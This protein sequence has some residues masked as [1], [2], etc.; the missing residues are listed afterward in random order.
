MSFCVDFN[1]FLNKQ[2]VFEY[3]NLVLNEDFEK[4]K[5]IVEE[6]LNFVFEKFFEHEK[7]IG[8]LREFK[9]DYLD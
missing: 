1:H 6:Q 4:S 3:M 8:N 7:S 5:I 2:N 9:K